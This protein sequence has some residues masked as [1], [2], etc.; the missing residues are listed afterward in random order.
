MVARILSPEAFL[1]SRLTPVKQLTA[2]SVTPRIRP[3]T[4]ALS[5]RLPS[6]I[7]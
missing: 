7:R 5:G 3:A 6:S 2:T 4:A 1:R